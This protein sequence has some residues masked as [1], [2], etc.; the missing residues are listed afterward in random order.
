MSTLVDAVLLLVALLLC[1]SG[2][3]LLALSQDRN[4]RKVLD[5]RNATPP[6]FAWL[7]W[8]RV[9]SAFV[10]CVARDGAS[11]AALLWP[12]LF[13][14]GAGAAAMVLTYRP[15]WYGAAIRVLGLS[16]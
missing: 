6:I 4:W 12:L 13:A 11:F 8:T 7:G 5:D 9:L 2:C 1:L 3:S 14:A 16:R 15:R 10:P